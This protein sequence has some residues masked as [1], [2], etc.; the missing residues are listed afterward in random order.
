MFPYSLEVASLQTHMETLSALWK[1]VKQTDPQEFKGETL[2][3]IFL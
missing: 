1:V 2:S 3:Y